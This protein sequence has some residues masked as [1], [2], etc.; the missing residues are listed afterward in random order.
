MERL[1]ET[2]LWKNKRT[3]IKT[4]QAWGPLLIELPLSH[5]ISCPFLPW[6]K[7]MIG[8]FRYT[9]QAALSLT[10]NFF[11]VLLKYVRTFTC[12]SF[13]KIT[14]RNIFF[15]GQFEGISST[16]SLWKLRSERW[17]NCLQKYKISWSKRKAIYISL[18][19]YYFFVN[20]FSCDSFEK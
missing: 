18:Y 10:S 13:T 20:F 9:L 2:V 8:G 17:R 12:S 4:L 6:I 14:N 3:K 5:F 15:L 11:D 7:F 1:L 16:N 19:Q